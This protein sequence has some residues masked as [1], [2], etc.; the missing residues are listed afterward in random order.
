MAKAWRRSM[1][2]APV[3]TLP[4]GPV[5]TALAGE[6]V[7]ASSLAGYV[8]THFLLW[9]TSA[10]GVDGWLFFSE[11]PIAADPSSELFGGFSGE[12]AR[13]AITTGDTIPIT[14]WSNVVQILA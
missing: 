14:Q 13:A 5:L 3:P 12:F 11:Q 2:W 7:E 10:N 9:Q 1:T 8:G 4:V 6:E